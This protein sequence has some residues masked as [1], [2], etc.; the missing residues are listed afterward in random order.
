MKQ[1]TIKKSIE[2]LIFNLHFFIF[3]IEN[4]LKAQLIRK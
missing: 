1:T 2:Y 4:R 3:S